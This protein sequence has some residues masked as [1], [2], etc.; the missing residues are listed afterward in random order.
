VRLMWYNNAT[1][2]GMAFFYRG[3]VG[4]RL[5]WHN[6]AMLWGYGFFLFRSS[7]GVQ[8][9]GHNNVVRSMSAVSRTPP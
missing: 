7:A 5:M 8:R 9:W 4:V 3:N 1:L 6:N 2:W